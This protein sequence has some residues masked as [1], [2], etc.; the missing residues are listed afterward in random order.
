[1]GDDKSFQTFD[2][3]LPLS[4]PHIRLHKLGLDA[5]TKETLAPGKKYPHVLFSAPPS[6]SEDYAAEV[7][8]LVQIMGQASSV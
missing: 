7:G 4:M 1:M 6:G 8:G 2:H 3:A 5:A